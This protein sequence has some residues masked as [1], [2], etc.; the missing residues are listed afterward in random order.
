MQNTH[1]MVPSVVILGRPEMHTC[2]LNKWERK[3]KK[4]EAYV[5]FHASFMIVC[6]VAVGLLPL[7][8]TITSTYS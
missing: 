3:K 8:T 1:F 7:F 4:I 6:C 5:R 2:F